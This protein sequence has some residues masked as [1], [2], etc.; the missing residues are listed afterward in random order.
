MSG[1]VANYIGSLA[2]PVIFPLVAG[3]KTTIYTVEAKGRTLAT[4]TFINDT[5]G[6]V[7]CKLHFEDAS[8]AVEYVVWTKNVAANSTEAAEVHIRTADGDIIKATGASG[9][10]VM[11]EMV[12]QLENSR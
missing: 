2:E 6:A 3:T 8:K 12:V 11:L 9:V 10:N 7:Q 1:I 5:G 4:A